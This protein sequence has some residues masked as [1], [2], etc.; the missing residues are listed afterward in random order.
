MFLLVELTVLSAD[1]TA[2]LGAKCF[3]TSSRFGSSCTMFI[4]LTYDV[5]VS[6]KFE[7]KRLLDLLLSLSVDQQLRPASVAMCDQ[8]RVLQFHHYK[9]KNHHCTCKASLGHD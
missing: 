8:R 6:L 2:P 9:L 7:S 5:S 3:N 1:S 4:K